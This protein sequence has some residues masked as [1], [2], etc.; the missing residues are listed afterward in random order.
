MPKDLDIDCVSSCD[1]FS[2]MFS[3]SGN[4]RETQVKKG[5][6]VVDCEH[7]TLLFKAIEERQ[8]KSILSRM[9]MYPHEVSTFVYR[10]VH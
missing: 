1:S 2:N 9:S 10:Y 4:N 6:R 3:W 5:Q 8:W 7:G